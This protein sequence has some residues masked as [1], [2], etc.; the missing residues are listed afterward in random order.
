[1]LF[2]SAGRR[3][4]LKELRVRPAIDK[5]DLSYRVAQG[6]QFLEKGNKVQVVCIFRGRQL[7]H[8]EHGYN[9]M[10]EVAQSL[11][12]VS[13]VE[14]PAKMMGRRMTMTL[15]PSSQK[16]V[17]SAPASAPGPAT[18]ASAGG[19]PQSAAAAEGEATG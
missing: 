11:S 19:P 18:A 1:M 10:T 7:R 3:S 2:R 9:V 8:P 14:A 6:R 13:K 15:T 5:H 16:A 12:D 17:G 4:L